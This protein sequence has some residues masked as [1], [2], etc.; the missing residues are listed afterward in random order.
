[1]K[2]ALLPLILL[3]ALLATPSADAQTAKKAATPSVPSS[4]IE[5]KIETRLG[6]PLTAD[7]KQRTQRAAA[8]Y[9]RSLLAPHAK[10][11]QDLARSF[12]LT[13]EI[14]APMVPRGTLPS[15]TLDKVVTPKLEA[16]LARK[17]N[18]GELQRVKALDDGR[19]ALIKT[20]QDNYARQLSAVVA[21]PPNVIGEML[22]K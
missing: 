10:F 4:E 19:R 15:E 12:N 8:D 13:E 5:Q 17:L 11:I 2:S 21:L 22:P 7:Q 6:K 3:T 1:M 9:T 16:K 18:P 20:L 14:V